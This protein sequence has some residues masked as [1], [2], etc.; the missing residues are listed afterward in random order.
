MPLPNMPKPSLAGRATVRR[1]SSQLFAGRALSLS[2]N[3]RASDLT[4][5]GIPHGVGAGGKTPEA[6]LQRL[7]HLGVVAAGFVG[8]S[9]STRARR[10]GGGQALRPASP[11]AALTAA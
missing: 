8:G 7:D 5:C 1:T 3:W 11:S 9:M 10:G 6:V 4:S 2:G